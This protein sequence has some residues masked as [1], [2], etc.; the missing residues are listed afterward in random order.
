MTISVL[1]IGAGPAGMMAAGNAALRGCSVT[2]AD[3]N[4][5][6][7]RKLMITGKGRCNITNNCD[8]TQ[9]IANVPTNGRFLYSA[10]NGFTPQDTID[11][12]TNLGLEIKTERGNRVFP[13]SDKAVDVV[14]AMK[15]FVKQSKCTIIQR[16]ITSLIFKDGTVK[17]AVASN[18]EKL[19]ADKIVI[20][21]GG[22]S[23]PL[24][25]STGQG[26]ILARQ[27]GHTIVAP[28]PSLVSLE[29]SDE[30]CKELQGLSLRNISLTV[31][32]LNNK[33][34]YKDFGEMIFTHYGVSGPVILSA[35]AH[36]RHSKSTGHVISIDLKPALSEEQLDK[37]ILR[38]FD[39]FKNRDIANSLV[40][41]LPSTIVPIVFEKSGIP[42]QTK[43]NSVTKEQRRALMRALK[44]F[45]VKING[46]RPIEEAII[47]SGGVAVNEI[48][49]KTMESK[50]IKNLYFAGEVIDVDAYTGGFN[51]QI[52]F[53]TGNLAGISVANM[54]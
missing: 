7:G 16:E 49:P 23:Y 38:D 17:G 48:N 5:R 3:K 30:F 20:A 8:T 50:I 26:Y 40:K 10:I 51:L 6:V 34:I 43:C 14:D 37:R 11:F 52:A 12:F 1:V 2:L 42:P 27:V 54:C 9:F 53:S 45:T 33:E 25:G 24:T 21:C 47:T 18:G 4:Q 31:T 15:R 19:Y 32:D 41:L 29:S 35:S 39:E 44:G 28:K 22:K 46:F 36:L 13:V